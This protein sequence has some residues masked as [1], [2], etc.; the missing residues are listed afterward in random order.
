MMS[1]TPGKENNINLIENLTPVRFSVSPLG[2][3]CL[4]DSNITTCKDRLDAIISQLKSNFSKWQLAQQKGFAFCTSIESIKIRA[5]ESKES[6]R[7]LKENEET[8]YPR[9]LKPYIEKLNIILSIFEDITKSA[10][11]SL[12]QLIAL[13]KLV[14]NTDKVFHQSWPLSQYIN[15]LDQ[16]H[17]SYIQE[18]K[19]KQTVARELPHCMNRSDLIRCTSAWEY[20]QYIDEWTFLM[21]AF[22]KEE[23]KGI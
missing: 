16:L 8:L 11:E 20:P 19:V 18:N 13:G 4:Q 10:G 2:K 6:V 5:L 22:L 21:F 17:S 1:L 9:D 15:F 14:G 7:Q 3:S 23:N 12:R